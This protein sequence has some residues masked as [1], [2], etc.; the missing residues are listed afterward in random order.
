M[1][2]VQSLTRI[3]R[4]TPSAVP[5]TE[6]KAV[7]PIARRRGMP[8][9]AWLFLAPVS[10][11]LLALIAYPLIDVVWKS[12]HY[13]NLTNPTATGF[14]GFDNFLTVFQDDDIGPAVWNT[15]VWTVVSVIG[16]YTL[17]LASAV[18]LAGPIRGRAIFRAMIIIPWIIPIVVAGLDWTWILAPDYG[19][20]NLWLV[21]LGILSHPV[22][23]LGQLQTALLTVTLANIWRTFPFY[24]ISLLAALQAIPPE[25]HEAAALDGASAWRRFWSISLPHLRP[26]SLTLVTLHIIWT[27]VNFDFIWVMTEGGPLNS[28]T[29]LPILIYRYAMQNF[30]VGA[31]CALAGMMMS[32][33][34]T[35]FFVYHYGL[36]RSFGRLRNP[37]LVKE[38]A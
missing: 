1:G 18:A 17:G 3:R 29:T 36:V 16:E 2:A 4:A 19:V 22:N 8:R 15:V 28:S 34:A 21:H 25:L 37:R 13:V 9:I 6:T 14:S 20:L 10:I 27:S 32:A 30:D 38:M 35:M 7:A 24:T 23:W 5:A 33:I 11:I 31:A 26:V 12:F